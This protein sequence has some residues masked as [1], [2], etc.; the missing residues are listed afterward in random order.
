MNMK[1]KI[2][3]FVVVHDRLDCLKKSIQSYYDCIDDDFEI[4]FFDVES[5]YPET[6]DY[7]KEQEKE[8]IKVYWH[9]GNAE[10]SYLNVRIG[11]ID[12]FKKHN[13][14]QYY[15]VTD[16]DIE[17]DN[18]NGDILQ[19]YIHLLNTFRSAHCVGPML[20]IDD[21]SDS[22]PL[23]EKAIHGHTKQFWHK[24]PLSILY[25]G[26]QFHY[27]KAPIGGTFALYRRSVQFGKINPGIR[28]YAPY[29]ARHLDWYLDINN[30]T[31]DQK[32]YMDNAIHNGHWSGSF[33]RAYNKNK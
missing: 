12:Y 2:P 25:N 14:S 28:T 21:I 15:V 13:K 22:Y 23:K 7:L 5:T 3:I 26:K 10:D 6:I 18:V 11:I 19:F 32:F 31:P 33:L 20:R 17:L 30:L 8:G 27:Q 24:N 4:V 16:P 29:A 9:K 1:Y